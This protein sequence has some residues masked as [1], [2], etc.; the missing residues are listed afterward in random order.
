MS[1]L[2]TPKFTR[3]QLECEGGLVSVSGF[4]KA[5]LGDKSPS[6]HSWN[7][8]KHLVNIGALDESLLRRASYTANRMITSA[9]APD[10]LVASLRAYVEKDPSPLISKF[11]C[12][13][14]INQFESVYLKGG[15]DGGS[16]G[17]GAVGSS[18][19]RSRPQRRAATKKRR[20]YDSSSEDTS[21]EKDAAQALVSGFYQGPPAPTLQWGWPPLPAPQPPVSH[22]APP[23]A[24]VSSQPA[25]PP[26]PPSILSSILPSVPKPAAQMVPKPAAQL[27]PLP[28]PPES[29]SGPDK[30]LDEMKKY[31][32]HLAKKQRRLNIL[33]EAFTQAGDDK[34][35]AEYIAKSFKQVLE[36]K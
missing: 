36:S 27:P 15:G 23:P 33:T 14:F 10:V 11:S 6:F 19:Q 1:S 26:V 5:A 30:I 17:S 16:S 13:E 29:K 3:S 32:E 4:F 12:E 8:R 21:D 31:T 25:Q 22:Q 28:V 18:Q 7:F 20:Y 24:P 2:P 35:F 9:A 34:V